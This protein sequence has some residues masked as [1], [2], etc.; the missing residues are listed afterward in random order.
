MRKLIPIGLITAVSAALACSWFAYSVS[1]QDA[2]WFTA[3]ASK[4]GP[5]WEGLLDEPNA[6]SAYEVLGF[7]AYA[8]PKRIPDA[9]PGDSSELKAWFYVPKQDQGKSTPD[10]VTIR[11]KQIASRTNYLLKSKPI[12]V[13]SRR[14]IWIPFSW[15]TGPFILRYQINP[16]NLAVLAR[17]ETNDRDEND[18]AQNDILPVVFSQ[19]QDC[20]NE[21]I[22]RYGL[23]LKIQRYS[24]ADLTYEVRLP[25]SGEKPAMSK[26][27]YF[28]FSDSDTCAPQPPRE[29]TG[30]EVGTVVEL[31]IPVNAPAGPVSLSIKGRYKDSSE[32]LDL[33]CR[34]FHQPDFQ[35]TR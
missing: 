25:K 18:V 10:Y 1:G 8:G 19:S 29:R 24:L 11:A 15:K 34:F 17:L 16:K 2:R 23:M 20:K 32:G 21:Q 28:I 7:F 4:E 6:K 3:H 12:D 14:N 35:C 30:I 27:C 13:S 26:T 31:L 5:Y 33:T 22:S 9:P